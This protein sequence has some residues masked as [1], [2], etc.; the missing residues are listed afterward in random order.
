MR[1]PC[2]LALRARVGIIVWLTLFALLQSAWLAQADAKE[3][4]TDATAAVASG[5]EFER[6]RQWLEA[7]EIYESSLKQW[8]DSKDLQYGLRRSKA[9]F[10]IERRYADGSFD[11][12]LLSK[13]KP[14][15]LSTFDDLLQ[16]VRSNYVDSVSA[17]SFVAHGTESL[18]LALANDRFL[19]R[20]LPNADRDRI[21]EVRAILR[22][23]Y[24]NKPLAN[25]S[26]A[27]TTVSEICD[28]A[29]SKLSL[30]PGAVVMEY[31]FGGCN[32]LDD[33]SCFL[34]PDR[35]DDL[36]GNIEGE[37]VGLGIEMKS[38]SGKGMLLANV[39]PESPAAEGGLR[40]GDFIVMIDGSDCRAMT[41]DEAAKLLR[42]P[43]NSRVKLRV[44][45][46]EAE[47]PL[48]GMFVRRAVHVKSIPV[49]KI[50]DETNGIG[51]IQMTGFQ[52][53]SAQELDEALVKLKGQG[54]KALIWDVRGNPGGL[55]TA[56]VEVLDRFVNDGVLVST[57]GR[58]SD[59]NWTYSAHRTAK[60][61]IPLVLLVDGDSASASEIVAGALKDHRRGTIVGRQSFGKWS[62][63]SIFPLREQTGLRL[64]TAKFYSPHGHTLGKIGVRPDVVIDQ[65]E[66]TGGRKA[67]Y[68]GGSEPGDSADPDVDAGIN[69]LRRQLAS[70]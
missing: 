21:G 26:A 43:A 62:V 60:Y 20:N 30:R 50:V 68:R 5:V 55:L 67:A 32:A 14:E 19:A 29:S 37:F 46:E 54:M 66:S 12:Q 28:I 56:A 38:E 11:R 39:L 24:W 61:N 27:H 9:H 10:S 45:R 34:T 35:L 22:D 57:K 15:A 2:T 52:K 63:Q 42:G 65:T 49:A 58:S 8:P 41:T 48:E 69:V 25:D 40:K 53:T 4:P 33:Y 6:S 13:S 3:K 36:Y 17:T 7:I 31:V 16:Q 47:S 51:Y 18:Y 1:L 64:T 44:E 70:R 23:R 59:Q